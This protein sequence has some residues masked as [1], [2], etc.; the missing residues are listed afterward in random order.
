MHHVALYRTRTNDR[1][2]D[3]EIVIAAR[4]QP[5][6]HRHLCTRFDLKDTHRVAIADHVV[7][8]RVLG[9][10]RCERVF[11]PVVFPDQ[12]KA[13]A[14]GRQHAEAQHI[15]FEKAEIFK[16]ILLPLND[17]AIFHRGVFNRHQLRQRPV[18]DNES[19]HVLRQM[20]REA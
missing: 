13:P 7:D 1:D 9:R 12:V 20:T 15:H 16:V 11:P 17:R 18:A 10:H 6:Q 5:R 14:Y 4:F 19:A 2:F 8:D 3:D